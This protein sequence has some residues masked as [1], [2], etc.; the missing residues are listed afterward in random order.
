MIG[1]N[2]QPLADEQ[3]SFSRVIGSGEPIHDLR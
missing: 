3:L 2:E 1:Q